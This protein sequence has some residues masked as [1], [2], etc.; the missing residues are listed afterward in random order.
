MEHGD[1]D[2]VS[3]DVNLEGIVTRLNRVRARTRARLANS[4]LTR[5]F[6]DTALALADEAFR[7]R[8]VFVS[9][10]VSPALGYLSRARI[11][12]RTLGDYPGLVPTEA[13]FRDRWA[14][15]QD[16]LADF[17]SYALSV[18]QIRFERALA[19][20]SRELRDSGEDFSRALHRFAYEATTVMLDVPAHRLQLFAIAAASADPSASASIARLYASL[21]DIWFRECVGLAEWFGVELRAGLSLEEFSIIVQSAMEGMGLRMIA[22][23]DEP[24]VDHERKT[25]LIGTLMLALVVAPPDAER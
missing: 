6:L 7:S 11:V 1:H 22:G 3:H 9:E 13:K 17:V 19:E 24:L 21:S 18:R 8:S 4:E 10:D 15:Q 2:V 5:A 14:G 25:S 12:A 23:L 16:F 20:C